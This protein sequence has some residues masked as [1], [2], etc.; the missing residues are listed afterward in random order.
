MGRPLRIP[1]FDGVEN[2]VVVVVFVDEFRYGL[3]EF[4]K[5]AEEEAK[6]EAEK[7][8]KEYTKSA[9]EIKKVSE[10][11]IIETAKMLVKEVLP[12]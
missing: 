3:D 12:E 10:E 4:L 2:L 8:E 6:Q 7:T 9:E 5:E 11:K 1:V